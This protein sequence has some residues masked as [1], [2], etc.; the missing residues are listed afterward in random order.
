MK[1]ENGALAERAPFLLLRLIPF[2]ELTAPSQWW[3]LTKAYDLLDKFEGAFDD[4][5]RKISTKLS[6]VTRMK[7]KRTQVRSKT[8]AERNGVTFYENP[9]LYLE[10]WP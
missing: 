9:F 10:I 5:N 1:L 4:F 6:S 7:T 8:S 3:K 2:P